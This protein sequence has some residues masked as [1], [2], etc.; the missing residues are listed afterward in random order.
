[1]NGYLT[2]KCCT[3]PKIEITWFSYG[4]KVSKIMLN[5]AAASSFVDKL[6]CDSID[7]SVKFL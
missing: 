5:D 2:Q 4:I 3:L 7:Y 1:M 6:H